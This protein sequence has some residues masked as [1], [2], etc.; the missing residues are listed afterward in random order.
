VPKSDPFGVCAVPFLDD[1]Q[2][3]AT[4]KEAAAPAASARVTAFPSVQEPERQLGPHRRLSRRSGAEGRGGLV[5]EDIGCSRQI[6]Q[7]EDV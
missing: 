7:I 1:L 6:E 2:C 3:A 5:A 4:G